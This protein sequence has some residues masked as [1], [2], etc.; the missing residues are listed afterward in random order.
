MSEVKQHKILIVDDEPDILKALDRGLHREPY[1]S[2]F[3]DSG[4]NALEIFVEHKISVI[5]TDM[6]MPGMNGLELLQMVEDIS[7]ETIKIVLTGYTK[8]PQIL[9][10]V[11]RVD[12]F[13]F[14]TKPWDLENELKVYIR[15]AIE[16]YEERQNTLQLVNS[17][18]KKKDVYQKLLTDGYEKADHF[19]GLY[20][21]LIKVINYHHLLSIE[22]FRQIKKE[23]NQE[24][25]QEHLE[26][27]VQ[28]LNMRMNFINRV[29]DFSKY[30]LKPF[31]IHDIAKIIERQINYKTTIAIE[32][33]DKKI[34]Y[35]DN[36]KLVMGIIAEILDFP[37]HYQVAIRQLALRED[38][39]NGQN[40]FFFK[41]VSDSN[42]RM[43]REIEENEQFIK[44][45]ILSVDGVIDHKFEDEEVHITVAF[46][47]K[48]Q[49]AI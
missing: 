4:A 35:H 11:N 34:K 27:G 40:V 31:T 8:L 30:A 24:V 32:S 10:T 49:G 33:L 39:S 29:F 25:M 36:L 41:M 6:R 28:H 43:I 21:K 16:L 12:I 46:K 5:V 15:E 18:G 17:E 19:M 13:K 20:E 2:L 7:P 44:M 38:I 47:L 42:Q 26:K 48:V 23:R 14:L 37:M 3:A 22:E 1:T 9:A 45:V